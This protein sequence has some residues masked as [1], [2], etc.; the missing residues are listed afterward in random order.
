MEPR[1]NWDSVLS[2]E[3]YDLGNDFL[4]T[5]NVIDDRKYSGV[6][7]ELSQKLRRQMMWME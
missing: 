4:E 6:T 5:Q 7:N 1:Y 3:L 2:R